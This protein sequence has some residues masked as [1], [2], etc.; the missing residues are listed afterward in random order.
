[1]ARFYIEE[2]RRKQPH[3]PYFLGGLCAGGVIA[4]EMSSQL[5][6]AGQSVEFLAILEA[7]TPQVPI[8]RL[9]TTKRH[10]SDMLIQS[11]SKGRLDKWSIVIGALRVSVMTLARKIGEQRER[12]WLRARF[13]LLRQVSKRRL[14]WPRS[15]RE[16]SAMQICESAGSRYVPKPL[17]CTSVVLVR[18][19]RSLA[20][21]GARN[22]R[23]LP[24]RAA[25]RRYRYTP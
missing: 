6:C 10:F 21:A 17:R 25:A 22:H 12:W 11:R 18:A 19:K 7:V 20:G 16:L 13:Y 9:L 23:T 4:Y 24:A 1:M 2:V 15:I 8:R 14:P 5:L 3:G